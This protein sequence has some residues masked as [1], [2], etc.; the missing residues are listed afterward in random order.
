MMKT[1]TFMLLALL[2]FL[3]S[4]SY[5]TKAEDYRKRAEACEAEKAAMQTTRD[6]ELARLKKNRQIIEASLRAE[7][8]SGHARVTELKGRLSVNLVEKILFNSGEAELL[9]QAR[10]VMDRVGAFLN[11]IPD[12]DVRIEGHTDSVPIGEKLKYKYPTNWGLS[13][14]RATEIARYLQDVAK[15]EPMRLSAVGYGKF[16]PIADNNT[17]EGRGINRR[18]EIQ[19]ISPE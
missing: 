9:P 18:I 3:A 17:A 6:A 13:A 5:Q 15:V 2:P 8:Q 11:T 14:A 10:D 7:I 19:L 12:K 16:R 1:N 4:C